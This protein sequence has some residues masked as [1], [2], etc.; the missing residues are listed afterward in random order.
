MIVVDNTEDATDGFKVTTT[1]DT[2]GITAAGRT[3]AAVDDTAVTVVATSATTVTGDSQVTI[4]GAKSGNVTTAEDL[5]GT[6]KT[7]TAGEKD[8][9]ITI[10]DKP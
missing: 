8:I 10:T 9:T 3:Y 5:D 7:V 4:T 6:G 2:T 1:K